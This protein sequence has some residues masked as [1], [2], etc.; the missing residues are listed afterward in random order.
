M[1]FQGAKSL[2]REGNILKQKGFVE[3]PKIF[4][5][6]L[7]S[8]GHFGDDD[9]SN[10][11]IPRKLAT[12]I[13][14]L[15][16]NGVN[17]IRVFGFWPFGKGQEEEPYVKTEN[18]YDLNCFNE[19]YFNFLKEWVSYAN[20]RGIVVL[21][22]LFD[23]IG[24]KAKE[25]AQYNPFYQVVGEDHSAFSD[26]NH[27][28]LMG[29][30]RQ[31]V[32][33]VIETVKPNLNVIFGIMNEFR[34]DKWWHYEMSRYIKSLAPRCLISGSQEDSPA[35][36]DPNV[37]IW[38]IHTGRYDIET[39]R[40]DVLED[41]RLLRQRTGTEK[42]IGFSTSG[43]GRRGMVRENP[44]D[45]RRLVWDV[46]N[47]ELQFFGFADNKAY[48]QS[49]YDIEV[50]QLNVE[51]YK[52][53]VSEFQPTDFRR[54]IADTPPADYQPAQAPKLPEGYYDLF[55]VAALPTTHPEAFNEKGGR[56][57]RATLNQGF[58][59][60]GQYTSY[61]T[62]P[63]QAAFSVMIDNNTVDERAVLEIDVYNSTNNQVIVKRQITRRD[64]QLAG[65]FSV[66]KLEFTPPSSGAKLEFRIKY[67]GGAYVV[68]DKIA[69]VD[70]AKVY[71]V[72]RIP[73]KN[74]DGVLDIFDLS[75][76]LSNLPGV[77]TERDGK[78]I[79]K[80][81]T[82][83]LLCYGPV[84]NVSKK[85]GDFETVVNYKTGYPGIPLK[86]MFRVLTDATSV[87]MAN[88]LSILRLEVYDHRSQQVLA[89]KNI[90]RSM[91]AA[92]HKFLPFTL[93]FTPSEDAEL[94]FRVEYLG[95]AYILANQLIVFDPGKV[96]IIDPGESSGR[97][98]RETSSLGSRDFPGDEHPKTLSEEPTITEIFINVVSGLFRRNVPR[99][100]SL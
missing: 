40:S 39:G 31:Y 27:V 92:P 42:I 4:C 98:V 74:P 46:I 88:D 21:Y 59:C 57:V 99:R 78:A 28:R 9:M 50:S 37:D 90:T 64:F 69:I 96:E 12:T 66:F 52:A 29:L 83:G 62:I 77:F 16:Q 43:F 33:K 71:L 76:F 58:L 81:T 24:F 85:N 23:S 30:Q 7:R 72:P 3:N 84:I 17:G 49:S 14:I 36:D 8:F 25:F 56:A 26:L 18:G 38:F 65:E 67:L 100:R 55:D 11:D 93:G 48:Q 86:A 61:P 32:Q 41:V 2:V 34:G 22:E 70:P 60:F 80:T 10:A 47:A 6:E 54:P 82:K 44:L 35:T 5:V 79:H 87:V 89:E 15:A 73:T 13:D 51:T 45:M 1:V 20:E 19:K 95:G 97:L 68:A 63:L 94:E 53:I 75:Q 91:F